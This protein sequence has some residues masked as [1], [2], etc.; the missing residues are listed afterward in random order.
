M[1]NHFV[2][3]SERANGRLLI[4]ELEDGKEWMIFWE[5][6]EGGKDYLS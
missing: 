4:D 2:G 5:L 6:L 1:D 3:R